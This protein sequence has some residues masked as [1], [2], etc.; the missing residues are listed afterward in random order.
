MSDKIIKIMSEKG[1]LSLTS[2]EI[3]D[4]LGLT[5]V[6][7]YQELEKELNKLCNEGILYYSEK[8]KRYTLFKNTTF[9]KGKL[10]M[11]PKGY[12]F[13]IVDNSHEDIYIAGPNLLD[14]RN[15]DIVV[16]EYINKHNK[17]GKVIK[18]IY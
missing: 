12:G 4:K 17:E 15:N 13:V 8:K 5:T 10:M 9:I 14:A 2:I 7:E 6:E 1:N 11:N 16:V 3:N 18:V